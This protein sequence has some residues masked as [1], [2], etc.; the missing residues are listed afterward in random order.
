VV[1][2]LDY[3]VAVIGSDGRVESSNPAADRIFGTGPE[4]LKNRPAN[5]ALDFSIYDTDG[6]LIVADRH[7]LTQI[8]Q[9]G[10]PISDYV[11][12]VD[13]FDGQR[14]WLSASYRLL[15]PDD[16]SIQRC[17]CH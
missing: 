7:P 6:H 4:V 8:R 5:R 9:T 3:G 15:K 12:G 16:P 11:F 13:R 1:T 2:T 10:T 17:S 14:V